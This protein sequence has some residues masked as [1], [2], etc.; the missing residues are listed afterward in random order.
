MF[1][2]YK[3]MEAMNE[4]RNASNVDIVFSLDVLDENQFK[5]VLDGSTRL[6]SG[7][8]KGKKWTILIRD[9]V[10]ASNDVN[11]TNMYHGPSVKLI[12][13]G[14]PKGR[15]AKKYSSVDGTPLIV[16]EGIY[17]TN[18]KYWDSSDRLFYDEHISRIDPD[19]QKYLTNF[20]LYNQG[21]LIRYWYS[22]D[23]N[24]QNKIKKIILDSLKRVDFNSG[25][26]IPLTEDEYNYQLTEKL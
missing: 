22:R 20:V 8:T 17:N 24:E 19:M 21:Y 23:I 13:H 16:K 3:L 4:T 12:V 25:N 10:S 1:D 26:F 6:M 7:S 9:E 5:A 15:I 14:D 2:V 18:K 11:N